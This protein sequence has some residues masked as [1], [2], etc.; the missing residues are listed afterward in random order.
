M[1]G[2]LGGWARQASF[3]PLRVPVQLVPDIL[4]TLSTIPGSFRRTMKKHGEV[5][6][7]TKASKILSRDCLKVQSR[8]S[9]EEPREDE[10]IFLITQDNISRKGQPVV[11][12]WSST[13]IILSQTGGSIP[14]QLRAALNLRLSTSKETFDLSRWKWSLTITEHLAGTVLS[15]YTL[16]KSSKQSYEVDSFIS[17]L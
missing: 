9:T 12:S 14:Q 2:R 8:V 5:Y 13:K 10:D 3:L 15:F 7:K 11:T 1:V 4:Q 6:W 16:T 17:I